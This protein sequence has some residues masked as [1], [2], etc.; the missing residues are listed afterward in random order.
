MKRSDFIKSLG[1]SAGG[2]VLPNNLLLAPQKI[3]IYDN[4]IKGIA[5]YKYKR[6]MGDLKEGDT[7]V[8]KREPENLY[9]TFAI[10]IFYKRKKLGYVTAY[11]NVVLA[12]MMDNNVELK[13]IVSKHKPENDIF[14]SIAVSIYAKLIVP[15]QKLISMLHT[16]YRSDDAVDIYR[17]GPF[18]L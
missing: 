3:K 8:L 6:V 10:E 18:D 15:S 14:S 7:L 9:D 5:H 17:K 12:N 16:T 13:A 11:E 1:L 2:V 4:Y